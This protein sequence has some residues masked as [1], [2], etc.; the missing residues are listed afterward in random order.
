MVWREGVVGLKA[1][2]YDRA[3]L[4]LTTGWYR[5]VL[6]RVPTGS[7]ILDVGIGTGG[8]LASNASLLIER[9]LHVIGVDI[10]PDYVNR[11]RRRMVRAGLEERVD[12][13]LLSIYDYEETGFDAAYFSASFMLLPDRER[14]V[15]HVNGL[16]AP[17][18]RVFF[19]QTFQKRRSRVLEAMKPM[20]RAL[21]T[22]DFGEVTYEDDF[23]AVLASAGLR[24]T[25]TDTLGGRG[26]WSYRLVVAA[27]R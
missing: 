7:R 24:V 2:I 16:L 14:A 27:P 6:L 11:C 26:D 8:A 19:T 15:R 17:G 9:D 18:A 12:T 5:E 20:L 13:R 21:T 4:S 1:W 3:L 25:E 10:D 23:L 22:V